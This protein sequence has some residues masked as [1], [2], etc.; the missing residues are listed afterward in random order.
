M[1]MTP[2]HMVYGSY[3][4]D[5]TSFNSISTQIFAKLDVPLPHI[6]GIGLG[7]HQWAYSIPEDPESS[8][9]NGPEVHIRLGLG[10]IGA[11]IELQ[12]TRR[13]CKQS[14][15]IASIVPPHIIHS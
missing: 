3:W 12:V 14:V 7:Q 2:L 4:I 13:I 11:Y 10:L 1:S 5:I 8:I 9:I 15:V 6:Q